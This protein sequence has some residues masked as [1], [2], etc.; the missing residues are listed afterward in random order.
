MTRMFEFGLGTGQA[1]ASS[2]T[3]RAW[4]FSKLLGLFVVCAN[5]IC[6]N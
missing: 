2:I 5:G 3:D 4:L 6:G 1:G